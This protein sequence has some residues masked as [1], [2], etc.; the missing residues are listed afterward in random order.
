MQPHA[1]KE[2]ARRV[3]SCSPLG[4]YAVP[5][6]QLRTLVGVERIASALVEAKSFLPDLAALTGRAIELPGRYFGSS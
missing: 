1:A 2:L 6:S 3:L 4:A 5:L